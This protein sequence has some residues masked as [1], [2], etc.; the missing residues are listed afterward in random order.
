MKTAIMYSP[1]CIH[2]HSDLSNN[3]NF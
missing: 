2:L 3:N 1:S